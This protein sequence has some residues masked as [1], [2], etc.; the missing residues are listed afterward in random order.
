MTWL[1]GQAYGAFGLG[2]L[3]GVDAAANTLVALLVLLLL[4]VPMRRRATA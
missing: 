1:D 3:F 4:V 2:G